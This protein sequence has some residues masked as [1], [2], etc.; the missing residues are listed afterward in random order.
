MKEEIATELLTNAWNFN[1]SAIVLV[2]ILS[3]FLI[4]CGALFIRQMD[5]GIITRCV[6]YGLT[7]GSIVV[8]GIAG[9]IAFGG[10]YI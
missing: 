5:N 1:V 3:G 4:L 9:Y 6:F 10:F 7:A 8:F 2:A